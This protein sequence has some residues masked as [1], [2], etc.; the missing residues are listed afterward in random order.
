M[1]RSK[2]KKILVVTPVYPQTEKSNSVPGFIRD[3]CTTLTEQDYLVDVLT[4]YCEGAKPITR[5]NS[6]TIYRFRYTL[7]GLHA[8]THNTDTD[9]T[10]AASPIPPLWRP[11]YHFFLYRKLAKLVSLYDYEAIHTHWL[12]PQGWAAAKLCST[13]EKSIPLICS[14]Y[15]LDLQELE[16]FDRTARQLALQVSDRITVSSHHAQEQLT[17]IDPQ[18]AHKISVLHLGVDLNSLFCPMPYVK[19][20]KNALLFVGRLTAETGLQTLLQAMP[21]IQAEIP[22]IRLFVVGDGPERTALEEQAKEYGCYQNLQF[23]GNL[24]PPA[25]ALLYNKA[26]MLVIPNQ[27]IESETTP[28]EEVRMAQICIEAM[29]CKCPVLASALKTI[30][31]IV[32]DGETG[33]TFQAGSAEAL[34]NQ[35]LWMLNHPQETKTFASTAQQYVQERF[36]L[37]KMGEAYM[38]VMPL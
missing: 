37:A 24:A 27:P 28:A 32:I 35:I 38:S 20:Q 3:L 36:D 34:A 7:P 22:E 16:G 15:G 17:Q 14:A 30:E 9:S 6:I 18:V 1:A 5:Y 12:T 2:K 4:P 25:I 11:L 10:I 19:R 23:V 29:G 31:D 21:T 33:K 13:R 26:S 8:K